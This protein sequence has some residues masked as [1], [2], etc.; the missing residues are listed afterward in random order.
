MGQTVYVKYCNAENIQM[1]ISGFSAGM[2]FVKI[3]DK[4][5]KKFV[6]E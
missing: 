6:K 4:D 3:N 5:V 2:Y 1:D